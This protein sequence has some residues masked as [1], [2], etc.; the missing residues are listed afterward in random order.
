MKIQLSAR[1]NI[2]EIEDHFNSAGTLKVKFS[3]FN[4]TNFEYVM[5]EDL[6]AYL[7]L[8]GQ[9]EETLGQPLPFCLPKVWPYTTIGMAVDFV[10][11]S[12]D[13][14]AIKASTSQAHHIDVI[15][16]HTDG[17]MGSFQGTTEDE[18]CNGRG[19]CS[20][21]NGRCDCFEGFRSGDGQGGPGPLGD[22][23]YQEHVF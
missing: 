21:V 14:P 3:W 4:L 19:I 12:G 8:N 1:S 7:L 9:D 11:D 18:P 13:V 22:C 2:E 6:A 17:E 16:V 20:E 10:S 23:G 5:E 15:N